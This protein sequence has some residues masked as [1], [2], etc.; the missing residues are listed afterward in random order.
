MFLFIESHFILITTFHWKLYILN[1]TYN[2]LYIFIYIQI[3]S[4]RIL[5]N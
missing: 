2:G 5:A 3:K 1:S 4:T